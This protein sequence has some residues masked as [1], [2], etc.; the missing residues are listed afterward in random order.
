MCLVVW[1][2][3]DIL[4]AAQL[5]LATNSLKMSWNK[6]TFWIAGQ[7]GKRSSPAIA[8][9]SFLF[10][11]FRTNDYPAYLQMEITMFFVCDYLK[12]TGVAF[13]L[14][15]NRL[16]CWVL[17]PLCVKSLDCAMTENWRFEVFLGSCVSPKNLALKHA[18]RTDDF[19]V[20]AQTEGL[21]WWDSIMQME[22]QSAGC[23]GASRPAW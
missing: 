7:L 20:T 3:F 15:L 5:S 9:R 10:F 1:E 12:S 22:I 17:V 6:W 14:H 18:R 2:K 8:S 16:S 21:W 19:P 4:F 13:G 11:F 23:L